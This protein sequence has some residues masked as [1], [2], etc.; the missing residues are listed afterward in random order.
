MSL[1]ITNPGVEN[2][3]RGFSDRRVCAAA[4]NEELVFKGEGFPKTDIAERPRGD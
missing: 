2:L 3:V 1:S 4:A